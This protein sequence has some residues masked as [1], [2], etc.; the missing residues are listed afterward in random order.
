MAA[1][2]SIY[3]S[4]SIGVTGNTPNA[5]IYYTSNGS[6]S[7]TIYSMAYTDANGNTS[8]RTDLVSYNG[9]PL[10]HGDVEGQHTHIYTNF[11]LYTKSDGTQ[12]WTWN[13]QIIPY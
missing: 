6:A 3:T 9:Q 10:G 2:C 7:G 8:A 4:S 13:E 1:Y 11:N 5:T 12:H